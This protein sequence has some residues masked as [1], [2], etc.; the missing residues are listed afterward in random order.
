M[1]VTVP[2]QE[3][4]VCSVLSNGGAARS[5]GTAG[6]VVVSRAGRGAEA[7]LPRQTA[8]M[9]ARLRVA[10]APEAASLSSFM[11]ERNHWDGEKW[12]AR[13]AKN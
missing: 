7:G 10:G 1:D 8:D 9:A 5:E 6:T 3:P 12:K 4:S 13:K 11:G 2:L